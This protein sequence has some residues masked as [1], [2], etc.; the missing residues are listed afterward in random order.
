M[1][2]CRFMYVCLHTCFTFL[3]IENTDTIWLQVC[4]GQQCSSFEGCI[5][6]NYYIGYFNTNTSKTFLQKQIYKPQLTV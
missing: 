1:H 2:V 6:C 4:E 3:H 5:V